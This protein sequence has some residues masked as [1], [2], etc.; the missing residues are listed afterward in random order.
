MAILTENV[1]FFSLAKW[2]VAEGHPPQRYSDDKNTLVTKKENQ[3]SPS[4]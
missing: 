3:K 1:K 4:I 2:G